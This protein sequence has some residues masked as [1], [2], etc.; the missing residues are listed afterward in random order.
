MFSFRKEKREESLE[1]DQ[2]TKK[3]TQ[4]QYNACRNRHFSS[5]FLVLCPVCVCMCV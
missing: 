3:Q 2:V 5:L 4:M 1:S